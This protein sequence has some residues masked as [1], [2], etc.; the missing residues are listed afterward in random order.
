MMKLYIVLA[1]TALG[2]A[3][4]TGQQMPTKEQ[5]IAAATLPLPEGVRAGASVQTIAED[6][7]VTELRKG[8]N[9]MVCSISPGSEEKAALF[10]VH[11]FEK[12]YNAMSQWLAQARRD[13][14]K[15]GQPPDEATLMAAFRKDVAS[16]RVKAPSQP[17]VGFQMRGP[18]KAFDWKTNTPTA[19]IR[20][21]EMIMIPNVTGAQLN[22]PNSRPKD[23]GLWVMNEGTPAAHIM[24]EH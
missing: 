23:R 16:G 14:T 10:A 18:A 20:R 22:L 7:K 1:V 5:Q 24:V 9:S 4:L 11:C 6:G 19:E 17:S 3:N 12:E 15:N 21:W 8:T 2:V 13:L